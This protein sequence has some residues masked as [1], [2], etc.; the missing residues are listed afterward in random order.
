MIQQ[1]HK[2]CTRCGRL[3]PVDAFG[4]DS[5]AKGKRKSVCRACRATSSKAKAKPAPLVVPTD[6]A[7]PPGALYERMKERRKDEEWE[8]P[9]EW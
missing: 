2:T 7:L 9:Y 1:T 5:K 8:P 4:W 6:A 3:L